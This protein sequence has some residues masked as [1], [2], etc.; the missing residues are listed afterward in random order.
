MILFI[1]NKFK[2][3]IKCNKPQAKI[4][5]K[6]EKCIFW[7]SKPNKCFQPLIQPHSH[8]KTRPITSTKL[9]FTIW[10]SSK[11]NTLFKYKP[12]RSATK[13]HQT[14]WTLWSSPTKRT[15]PT[16]ARLTRFQLG[17]RSQLAWPSKR[18]EWLKPSNNN[19][20]NRIHQF[21]YLHYTRIW[22]RY[23]NH[24]S[25]TQRSW[26]RRTKNSGRLQQMIELALRRP[27]RTRRQS[28]LQLAP[29]WTCQ[30]TESNRQHHQKSRSQL[31]RQI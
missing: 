8:Q 13:L 17:T 1:I 12:T 27:N 9:N 11:T 15:W 19:K 10:N 21:L 6:W 30:P 7:T 16:I 25:R 5:I 14:L 3:E 26:R 29:A 23:K 20:N 24:I 4:K 2:S 22:P 18:Q 28:E 31:F